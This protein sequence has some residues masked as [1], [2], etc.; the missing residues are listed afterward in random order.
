MVLLAASYRIHV[1]DQKVVQEADRFSA[2]FESYSNTPRFISRL[3]RIVHLSVLRD[4]PR[5]YTV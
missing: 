5:A 4:A 2:A 3:I 1:P